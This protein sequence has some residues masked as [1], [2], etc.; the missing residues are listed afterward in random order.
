VR[1][2]VHAELPDAHI[3][4]DESIDGKR[5]ILEHLRPLVDVP[6]DTKDK[7]TYV[8]EHATAAQVSAAKNT[9]AYTQ[10]AAPYPAVV[11]SR[12]ANAIVRDREIAKAT[13]DN[14]AAFR[15]YLAV[16]L[17]ELTKP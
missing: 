7:D 6:A 11:R 10:A 1:E 12:I 16:H 14:L 8:L 17:P 13:D 4:F 15:E 2:Q 3:H 5:L 9:A